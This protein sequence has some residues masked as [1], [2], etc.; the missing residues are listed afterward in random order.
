MTHSPTAHGPDAEAHG[1]V[2]APDH[3]PDFPGHCQQNSS[4][5][6]RGTASHQ[7]HPSR[8]MKIMGRFGIRPVVKIFQSVADITSKTDRADRHLC[9]QHPNRAPKITGQAQESNNSQ[10]I[11]MCY[12]HNPG[13][14][15]HET[16]H[17]PTAPEP[18]A[19]DRGAGS[20]PG[21]RSPPPQGAGVA[22]P[23]RASTASSRSTI[24]ASRRSI[25]GSASCQSPMRCNSSDPSEIPRQPSSGRPNSRQARATA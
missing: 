14:R 4:H 1:A 15:R 10:R 8:T 18:G 3:G 23:S 16:A 12:H 20:M 21:P 2:P 5:Q 7:Q 6:R 11:S 17:S 9:Q 22:S 24:P 19:E 13:N 25:S